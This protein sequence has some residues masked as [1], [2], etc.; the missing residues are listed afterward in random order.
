MRCHT[1]VLH[2]LGGFEAQQP[3]SNHGGAL[4]VV[5]FRVR[6]H[7]FQ[8]FNSPVHE[9]P[10]TL[11]AGNGRHEGVRARGKDGNVVRDNFTAGSRHGLCHRVNGHRLVVQQQL[12]VI[13][14]VPD[15]FPSGVKIG[16]HAQI[17]RIPRFEVRREFDAVVRGAGF[18]A[19]GGDGTFFVRVGVEEVFHEALSDHSVAD[20]YHAFGIFGCG[21]RREKGGGGGWCRCTDV[22]SPFCSCPRSEGFRDVEGCDW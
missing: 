7:S 17:G 1:H 5:F 16:R 11:S 21:R 4:D 6:Q 3:P 9:H 8:V 15:R 22:C 20:D 19:K 10:R 13:L 18:F 2:G 14:L 12:H